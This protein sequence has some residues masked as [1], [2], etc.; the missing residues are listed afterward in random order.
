MLKWLDIALLIHSINE[1]KKREGMSR[2]VDS[3]I[4]E[5]RNEK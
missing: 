1:D 4:S 5:S 3:S 2:K